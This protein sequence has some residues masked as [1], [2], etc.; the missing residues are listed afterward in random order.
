MIADHQYDH[1]NV[2][3]GHERDLGVKP[4]KITAVHGEQMS[5]VGG[6]LSRHTVSRIEQLPESLR[7]SCS[8]GKRDRRLQR[9]LQNIR[10][11]HLLPIVFPVVH[12]RDQPVR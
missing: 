12:Q 10:R 9:S 11:Q 4:G 3:V 8:V 2:V 1:A 5:P 7:F 6:G